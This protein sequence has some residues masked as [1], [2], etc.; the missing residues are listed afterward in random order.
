VADE[1]SE[2]ARALARGRFG[3]NVEPNQPSRVAEA[4]ELLAKQ[5]DLEEM[6]AAGRDFVRK[7]EFAKVL[8]E[9]EGTLKQMVRFHEAPPAPII[10]GRELQVVSED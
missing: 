1:T 4:I 7:F 8:T 5:N 9:F 3:V 10:P 2:L 6:G